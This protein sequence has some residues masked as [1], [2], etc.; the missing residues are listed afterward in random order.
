M[1]AA[2]TRRGEWGSEFPADLVRDFVHGALRHSAA[3][4]M[5]SEYVFDI[6]T[7]GEEPPADIGEALRVAIDEVLSAATGADWERVARDLLANAREC[8]E[9]AEAE[10]APLPEQPMPAG[11]HTPPQATGQTRRRR[12]PAIWIEQSE[13]LA[14][15]TE[16]RSATTAEIAQHFDINKYTVLRKADGLVA[17]GKLEVE[18]GGRGR[19]G[20]PR[21]YSIPAAA[22]PS[23]IVAPALPALSSA[24]PGPLELS[25]G[26]S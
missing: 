25:R 8:I 23:G 5:V 14:W 16:K 4:D 24:S 17:Q 21:R 6:A 15:V 2:E 9:D 7:S 20:H 10:A 19:Y 11:W 1:L 26:S 22:P 13:I 3:A 18:P 12:K